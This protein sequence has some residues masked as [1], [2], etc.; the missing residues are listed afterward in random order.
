MMFNCLSVHYMYCLVP[1]IYPNKGKKVEELE[2]NRKGGQGKLKGGKREEGKGK[3][4]HFP[5]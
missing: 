2:G 4:N 3:Q 5:C 1:D